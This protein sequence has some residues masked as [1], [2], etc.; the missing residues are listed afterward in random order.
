MNALSNWSVSKRLNFGFSLLLILSSAVIVIGVI[1]LNQFA[2]DAD[3]IISGNLKTERHVSDWLS[4]VRTGITRTKALMMSNNPALNAILDAEAKASTASSTELQ[5]TVGELMDSDKEKTVYKE[6]VEARAAYIAVRDRIQAQTKAG[7]ANEALRI[8]TTEFE[9]ISGNLYDKILT[10]QK[11]QREQIDAMSEDMRATSHQ[12]TLLLVVLGALSLAS[13]VVLSRLISASITRPLAQASEI[14]RRVASG[15]LTAQVPVHGRDEVGQLLDALSNMQASLIKVV[16]SVRRGS[17]SVAYASNEIAQGNSDLSARTEQQASALQETASS[18]EQLSSTVRQ[19]ADNAVQA[20]QLAQSA[21]A[22]AVEGG[23][24]VS[25]VVD[26]M[27]DINDSSRKIA[28]IISVIDGIAFQTNILA[29]NAAV[30]AARAGEQGRGFAVVASE[31]RSLAGR[32]ADA[33]KEIKA[34]IDDSVTRVERGSALV[35]KAG[36]TMAE[37]VTSIQR[38]TDIM[39]EISAASSEQSHGV[40][41][42]GTAV[43]HMD[44]ATQQNAALVE[45]MAAAASSLRSQAG[46]LVQTVATFK[47]LESDAVAVKAAAAGAG[48]SLSPAA[49]YGSLATKAVA[50]SPIRRSAARTV[51][52]ISTT[53]VGRSAPA[54]QAIA[55]KTPAG[56]DAD[57]EIF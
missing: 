53:K 42:V 40:L 9:P 46:E 57:W 52:A 21:S 20:N 8:F 28:D 41:Q 55:S 24:V 32:S 26:T 29:L 23:E 36:H 11:L 16:A 37:V 18:M 7:N 35:D 6:A 39:G 10:L 30:E 47:L 2:K 54:S 56:S 17:D 25:Q 5:K 15:D 49:G 13:G 34:L 48:A 38:V 22:V 3:D 43:S 44:Q 19:N 12:S 45:E 31:V 4:N 1:R 14:T 51:S 27:K 50:A 33:A